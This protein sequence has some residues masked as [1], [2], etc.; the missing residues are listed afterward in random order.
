MLK[1]FFCTKEIKS[2]NGTYGINAYV[3]AESM[4]DALV[5]LK[6]EYPEEINECGDYGWDISIESMLD[7]P[8]VISFDK[9]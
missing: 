4:E 2:D 8:E 5:R 1:L 7:S 6:M 3:V 9:Y